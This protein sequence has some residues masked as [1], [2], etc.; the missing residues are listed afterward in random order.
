MHGDRSKRGI[1]L[2]MKEIRPNYHGTGY[3]KGEAW[4]VMVDLAK[5]TYAPRMLS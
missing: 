4:F 1:D 5:L 3:L 2:P